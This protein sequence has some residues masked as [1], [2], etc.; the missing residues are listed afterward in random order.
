MSYGE[1]NRQANRLAHKLIARGIRPNDHVGVIMNRNKHL[2]VALL[3]VLKS[4]AAYVPLD[5][6]Y[7]DSR[8]NYILQH[9]GRL[10]RFVKTENRWMCPFNSHWELLT[11][12]QIRQLPLFR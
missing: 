4:G 12:R 5:P 3:A 10:P 6:R 1:L 7:P 2:V 11:L 8:K 9:S